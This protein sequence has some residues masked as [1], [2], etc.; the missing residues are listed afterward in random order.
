MPPKKIITLKSDSYNRNSDNKDNRR[1]SDKRDGY[2][3]SSEKR[4]NYNR[5]SD[6][7]DGYNRSS[8]RK[9]SYNRGTDRKDGY[10]RNSDHRDSYNRGTDRKEGYSRDADKKDGY[11]RGT[12]RNDSNRSTGYNRGTD[13]NDSNRSTGYN[14]GTDRNDS[15]R[16]TGY[17]RGTDRN[18]S[19]RNTGY[20]RG[21]DRND[22]YNRGTGYNR[23]TDRKDSYN[24]GSDN[25]TDGYKKNYEKKDSYNRKPDYKREDSKFDDDSKPKRKRIV[26]SKKTDDDESDMVRLNKYIANSGICSRRE[27]D[28]YIIAG[29]VKINGEVATVLGTKVNPEDVVSF[30]DEPIKNERKV[31]LLLNK[32]K[33]FVSSMDDPHAEK[34]VFDLVKSACKERVYPVGRLD[35]AT[36][37]VLLFTNDGEIATRMLHPRYDV[38]KVYMVTLNKNISKNEMVDIANGIELEDGQI[39]AD[40]IYYS[41]PDIKDVV[42]IELHSGKN[43][44]VRRIFEHFGYSVEKLDRLNFAGFTK[45][46]LRRGRWRFLAENEINKLKM[47]MFK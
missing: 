39:H 4:D 38:K 19:N 27:A 20:N 12:D 41:D 33:G 43:R 31:Y 2:N 1:D 23:G 44:I 22:S 9:D 17:N 26:R 36:T 16:S 32:P 13:R 5:S 24:R 3:H 47:N 11:N 37:G 6:R 15:N 7:K 10:N 40:S 18:D 35:K 46:G 45:K 30:N 34:T 25:R 21:T 42:V 8:D 29:L 14:R 28:K